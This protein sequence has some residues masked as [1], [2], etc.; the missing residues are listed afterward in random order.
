MYPVAVS[1]GEVQVPAESNAIPAALP[2]IGLLMIPDVFHLADKPGFGD[3][4][5][6]GLVDRYGNR[7]SDFG[8]V[9]RAAVTGVSRVP[10]PAK[11]VMTP[12]VSTL[13]I[14]L[15]PP[16]TGVEVSRTVYRDVES[17]INS[18]L[19]ACPPSPEED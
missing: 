18:A 13:R 6:A 3:E 1:I 7:K 12:D 2:A 14:R 10:L 16:S 5:I 15:L 19:V 17:K 11:V 8:L 9:G 4:H